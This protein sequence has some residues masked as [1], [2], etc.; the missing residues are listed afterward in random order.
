MFL[1]DKDLQKL[2]VEDFITNESGKLEITAELYANVESVGVYGGGI[3]VPDTEL[4]F[5]RSGRRQTITCDLCEILES[6]RFDV[7]R[8][9]VKITVEVVE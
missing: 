8:K 2:I 5:K 4:T 1:T 7:N 3:A 9:K 6:W